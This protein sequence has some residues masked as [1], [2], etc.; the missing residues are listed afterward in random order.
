MA[1][2]TSA[3]KWYYRRMMQRRGGSGAG[4]SSEALLAFEKYADLGDGLTDLEKVVMAA[5]YI[6][7]E[8]TAGNHAKKDYETI[9]SLSGNNAL[10]DYIG[11]K[12]AT[13]VNAP[14]QSINGFTFDGETNYLNT[15]FIPSSD[16]VKYALNDAQAGAFVKVNDYADDYLFGCRSDGQVN[17][18]ILIP[19]SSNDRYL[20][21]I[22]ANTN[23]RYESTTIADKQ[24]VGVIKVDATHENIV[25][26]GN[27]VNQKSTVTTGVPT[28]SVYVGAYNTGIGD[29]PG[30]FADCT[31][32]SFYIGGVLADQS[33]NY[34]NIT[35]LLTALGVSL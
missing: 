1:I 30:A 4:F 15:N 20:A 17:N 32:S 21:R 34:Y 28:V 6:D 23:Q 11:G 3:H 5:L 24:H 25:L 29:L 26:N 12:V 18:C 19:Q 16:G 7:P 27:L 2:I 33:S 31:I 10:V 22:N 14:T 8:V 35:T 9:Y 13:A